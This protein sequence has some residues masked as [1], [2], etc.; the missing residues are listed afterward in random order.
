MAGING[1]MKNMRYLLSFSP[2][3]TIYGT[4]RAVKVQRPLSERRLMHQKGE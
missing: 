4:N 2:L 1:N 3:K